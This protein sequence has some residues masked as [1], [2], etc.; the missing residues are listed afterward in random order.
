MR[1]TS[2]EQ[3]EIKKAFLEIFEE[4]KIYLFG[5]R[6]DDTQR[7]GDIDLYLCPVKEFQDMRK[8]KT[9]FLVKLDLAIGEQKIDLVVAKDKNRTIEQVALRDGIE[10]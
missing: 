10:L 8:K 7:G 4:G 9:D 5:S 1:L 2:F 6:V 3:K